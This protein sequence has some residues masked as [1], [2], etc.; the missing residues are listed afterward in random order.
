ME[1]MWEMRRTWKR[2]KRAQEIIRKNNHKKTKFERTQEWM[3]IIRQKNEINQT[4]KEDTKN[5]NDAMI[6]L[7]NH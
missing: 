5:T 2:A 7:E 4:L 1:K 6:E 3:D